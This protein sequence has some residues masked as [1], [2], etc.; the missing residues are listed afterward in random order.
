MRN[1]KSIIFPAPA[2]LVLQF[3]DSVVNFKL[4][5]Q[6]FFKEHISPLMSSSMKWVSENVGFMPVVI[7]SFI[8]FILLVVVISKLVQSCPCL[9]C[10]FESLKAKLM[11]AS[12]LRSLIQ[13]YLLLFVTGLT[14]VIGDDDQKKAAGL[15]T[16][17]LLALY[18]IVA[19]SILKCKESDL[20]HP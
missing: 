11:W 3:V 12:I 18:P 15:G 14:Q 1:F 17:V 5:E 8:I 20:G 9:K 4:T 2:D 10:I 19:I 6:Q 7:G 16:V 13:S